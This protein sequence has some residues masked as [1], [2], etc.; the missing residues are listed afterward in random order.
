[1]L[2][3]AFIDHSVSDFFSRRRIFFHHLSILSEAIL[4]L[5]VFLLISKPVVGSLLAVIK[6][7]PFNETE[8]DHDS[9]DGFIRCVITFP[10]SLS[11]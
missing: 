9:C 6:N 2:G 7:K 8:A 10:L 11:P 4:L 3:E 1:M 5:T